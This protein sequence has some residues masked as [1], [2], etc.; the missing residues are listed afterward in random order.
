MFTTL[1]SRAQSTPSH[2]FLLSSALILSYN[3]HE[4][5]LVEVSFPVFPLKIF[6]S[7]H[8]PPCLLHVSNTSA[9]VL[10][11]LVLSA[12]KHKRLE[13]VVQF[14][15]F[16]CY[17]LVLLGPACSSVAC[18][19]TLTATLISYFQCFRLSVFFEPLFMVLYVE[20]Y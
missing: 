19:K 15:V 4:I 14:S 17:L 7:F 8:I 6:V 10:I 1:H 9:S 20:T 2:Q 3:L 18:F 12:E 13:P 16:S 5:W 11:S